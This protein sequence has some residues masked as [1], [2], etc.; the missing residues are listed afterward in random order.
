MYSYQGCSLNQQVEN[1]IKMEISLRNG[2]ASNLLLN[3]TG[4]LSASKNST[5]NLKFKG[6]I[7]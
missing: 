4:D 5:Q 2:G 1:L 6:N 7:R 3:L